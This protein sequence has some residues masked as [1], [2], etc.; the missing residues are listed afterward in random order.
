MRSMPWAG[1]GRR[2]PVRFDYNVAL[3][4]VVYLYL[5]TNSLVR[6]SR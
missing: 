1:R 4:R 6:L 5:D 2:H 3:V